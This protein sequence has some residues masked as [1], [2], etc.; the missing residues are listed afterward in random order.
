MV[1]PIMG[2]G[3]PGQTSYVSRPT[4]GTLFPEGHRTPPLITVAGAQHKDLHRSIHSP[5]QLCTHT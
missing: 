3:V 2:F 5:C 1:P 4:V